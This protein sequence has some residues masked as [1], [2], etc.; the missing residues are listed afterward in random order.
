MSTIATTYATNT[1]IIIDGSGSVAGMSKVRPINSIKMIS[2]ELTD[3]LSKLSTKDTI[4]LIHFT[5]KVQDV[6]TY[7]GYNSIVQSKI[8]SLR[9]IP[10]GNTDFTVAFKIIDSIPNYR[11]VIIISDGLNNFRS[12]TEM[13][14]NQL[15]LLAE[16]LKGETYFLLLNE[17]DLKAPIINFISNKENIHII[18]S[19]SEI[20]PL[21]DVTITTKESVISDANKKVKE[22]KEVKH[23]NYINYKLLKNIIIFIIALVLLL[24][25]A[26]FS[27]ELTP[28]YLM[29]NAGKLQMS[30]MF[31]YNL[32]KGLFQIVFNTLPQNMQEFLKKNL[33]S[34][35]N[36]NFG[37]VLPQNEQQK[38]ILDEIQKES[39]KRIKYKNGQID[40]SPVSRYTVKLP[41]SLDKCIPETLNPRDK[42]C[43]AQEIAGNLMLKDKK[44]AKIIAN[45]VGKSPLDI[46]IDDYTCWKDD[47]LNFGKP[48]HNPLTPHETVDGKYI[49]YVPK[50]FHDVNYGGLSHNGGVSLLKAIRIFL[51]ET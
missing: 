18:K 40:F 5:D 29:K 43:K 25:I 51:A 21:K 20:T 47:A 12:S 8:E 4:T 31:L 24:L 9:L 10:K 2:N 3:F 48:N 11:R 26:D 22:V 44:G 42:V 6:Y 30:I 13:V 41:G 39:G 36:F 38:S 28:L 17:F 23:N 16:R 49:M 45:Y 7:S 1:V 27:I 50:K 34:R 14:C 37:E 15:L 33:P 46:N 32:P 19:L 35:Q